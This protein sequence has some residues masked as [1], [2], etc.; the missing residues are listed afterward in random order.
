MMRW[1]ALA[2][3]VGACGGSAPSPEAPKQAPVSER[4]AEK[5]AK[6]LVA[7]IY[8]SIG[9]GDTDGL[10]SLLADPLIVFGPRRGD[11]MA[12]RADALPQT[13]GTSSRGKAKSVRRI[14]S[15]LTSER[16]S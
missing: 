6:D 14:A 5:G 3:L 15:C 2:A 9:D 11:A 10:M 12:T 4:K 7:E 13:A 16:S 1:V 8:E